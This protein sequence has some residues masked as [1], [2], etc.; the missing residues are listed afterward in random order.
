MVLICSLPELGQNG[1]TDNRRLLSSL[2]NLNTLDL[3]SN[4]ITMIQNLSSLLHLKELHLFDN[5]IDQADV[6]ALKAILVHAEITTVCVSLEKTRV[7][8]GN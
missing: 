3:S 6:N 4:N 7:C 5:P 1:C 2:V 8:K